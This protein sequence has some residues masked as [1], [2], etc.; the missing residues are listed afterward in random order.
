MKL[1]LIPLLLCLVS[2]VSAQ[3]LI[4]LNLSFNSKIETQTLS[5][6]EAFFLYTKAL[7]QQ[8]TIDTTVTNLDKQLIQTKNMLSFLEKKAA[9]TGRSKTDIATKTNLENETVILLTQKN[10]LL[11]LK[12]TAQSQIDFLKQHTP[13]EFNVEVL[14]KVY[15]ISPLKNPYP[16]VLLPIIDDAFSIKLAPDLSLALPVEF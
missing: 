13:Y 4:D 1:K 9:A 8:L 7:N 14:S 10:S 15:E 2:A 3:T 11:Q 6:K 12:D 5:P 16:V